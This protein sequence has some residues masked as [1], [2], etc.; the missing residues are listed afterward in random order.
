MKMLGIAISPKLPQGAKIVS[1]VNPY[2]LRQLARST[3]SDRELSNIVFLSDGIMLCWL[4]FLLKGTRLYRQSF[5]GTSIGGQ[6]LK[7]ASDSCARVAVVGG[8][9]SIAMDFAAYIRNWSKRLTIAY[10]RNG[11]FSSEAEMAQAAREIVNSQANLVIVGMGAVVQEKMLLALLR[12][13]FEGR[14]FTCGGFM[15]QTVARGLYYYPEWVNRLNIRWAFRL[16]SEPGRL[17]YRYFIEY[18]MFFWDLLF[19][20]GRRPR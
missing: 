18:P 2:S 3:I 16:A 9:S 15:D 7:E 5:D 6:I 13:G 12:E 10:T 17:W 8:N 1:F 20:S 14:A 19:W 4:A 11:Y